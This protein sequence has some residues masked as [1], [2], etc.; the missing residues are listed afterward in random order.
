MTA[1]TSDSAR[2]AK[3][4][5]ASLWQMFRSRR[6]LLVLVVLTVV[7]LI[8]VLI[9]PTV[10]TSPSQAERERQV[11]P[12]PPA[13]TPIVKQRLAQVE[14]VFCERA[15]EAHDLVASELA[16]RR[17]LVIEEVAVAPGDT[18][19]TGHHLVSM[20]GTP[21]V[22]VETEIPFY[23]N[24]VVGD[25]GADVQRLETALKEA[26]YHPGPVDEEFTVETL[27]A[28]QALLARLGSTPASQF[29]LANVESISPDTAVSEVR[30]VVG[31]IV[32][33][34]MPLLAL[35]SAAG[36]LTCPM[37]TP[38][39]PGSAVRLRA[40]DGEIA[41]VV[42]LVDESPE[43]GLA[44]FT[45]ETE[46]PLPPEQT[47]FDGDVITAE[48]DTEVLS[49]PVSALFGDGSQGMFVLVADGEAST[50]AEAQPERVEVT[51]GMIANGW[52]EITGDGLD[53]STLV[54]V[55]S[56]GGHAVGGPPVDGPPVGDQIPDGP[57]V[58]DQPFG[59]QPFGD[60]PFGDQP[61]G[62]QPVGDQPIGTT[63]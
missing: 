26:G 43:G 7:S 48:T 6:F 46:S 45:V 33:P 23:R 40:P 36:V 1:P 57:P 52:A 35:S 30:V 28:W 21:I 54:V 12:L 31:Q 53:E 20:S 17:L 5:R 9:V 51:V 62:D 55:R 63:S 61:V 18:I 38:V 58:G 29:D 13:T 39:R 25:R 10:T 44:T 37:A 59:D 14:F 3:S 41:G 50:D 34:G 56:V 11:P 60:Q 27:G 8:G 42:G 15:G 32:E 24:L 19:A 2:S 49:V 22:A 47:S 16:D 4:G